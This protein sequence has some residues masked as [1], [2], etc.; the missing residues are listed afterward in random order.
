M[1][2]SS[3]PS[4]LLFS[5]F[6]LF[7]FLVFAF[8]M[9][10]CLFTLV[11]S[12]GEWRKNNRSPRLTVPATVITKRMSFSRHAARRTTGEGA[13][14]YYFVTFEAESG[15]R[16]ELAVYGSEY[17][18]LAEGDHGRLTFQGTRFL[19]FDRDTV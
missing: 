19:A 10:I 13:H 1:P 9:G 15:D 11:R 3:A 12:L 14:T 2:I 4:H 16:F 6:P 17:G 7:F 8:I 18:L 5:L